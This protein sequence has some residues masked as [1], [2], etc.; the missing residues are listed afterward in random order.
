MVDTGNIRFRLRITVC[1]FLILLLSCTDRKPVPPTENINDKR[2]NNLFE[3]LSPTESGIHF[4]NV[5]KEGPTMNGLVYEYFY[6]G[7]GVAVGDFNGDDL[8]DIYFIS[9]LG[10]N[11]LYLNQGSLKFSDVTE[12]AR[13][14]GTYGFPTGVTTVDINAD[15][16]LD[17]YICKS[18]KFNDPDKRRN[19]LYVNQGNNPQGV[20]IFKEMAGDY[21]LDLPHFSTQ[22]AFFDYDRDG[23]LDMFL[24][25]HGL[26]NYPDKAIGAYK[27]KKSNFRG[28]RLFKNQNGKFIDVT[29]ETGII[30]NMLGFGL[31][32]AVGD[33]NNDGWP[34]IAVGHDYSGKDHIYINQQN[35]TFK[36]VVEQVTGHISNFSMGNDIADYNNDGLLDLITLDMMSEKNYDI[37]TSMSGMNPDRFYRHVDIGLHYQYMYN[38]L[39]LNNGVDPARNL[40]LFSDVAQ[41]AGISSTDWS[42]GPLFLDMDNDGLKDLFVGNGIKRDF[43]NN[44]FV[45]YRQKKQ[46]EAEEAI[47]QGKKIDEQAFV[48]DLLSKMP[49]RK[50]PNYFYANN[51]DLTFTNQS[52]VW[53][54]AVETSSNGAAYADLDNDGDLE[55]I[56]NNSDD[57]S[58]IYKNNT[59]ELGLGNYLRIDFSGPEKNIFGIGARVKIRYGDIQ[60]MQEHYLTRGFQSSVG[61]GLHFGLGKINKVDTVIVTWPD[62]KQQQLTNIAANQTITL[63][64]DKAAIVNPEKKKE[65]KPLFATIT[66][67][68]TGVDWRHEEN[69]FNDFERESLLPHKMSAFGPALATGDFDG[70]GLEDLFLGGAKNQK[71]VLFKQKAN[72]SFEVVVQEGFA[73]SKKYEDVDAMFFDADTDGDLD[74]YLV[75]GGNEEI[76]GSHHYQDRVYENINGKFVYDPDFLPSFKVSG[77]CVR[78]FDFDDDGDLDL[79]VGG[80]QY[81]GRYPTPVSSYLLRNDSEKDKIRFTDITA[82]AFPQLHEIGMVTDAICV[83]L[84]QD[85]KQDLVLV[86]EW[87]QPRIF[88]NTDGTFR[89]MTMEAGFENAS[90]WWNVITAADFD[91][92][93]DLDLVA[94]NLGLNY[95]YKASY[96]KPFKV[97]ATDFDQTGTFDIVLGYYEG[98]DLYPLRGR[99]CSSAQMPF[100]KKKFPTYDAFAKA[101]LKDVYGEDQLGNA[102]QYSAHTFATTYFE[103]QGNGSF[104]PHILPNLAQVSSVNDIV[105]EDFDQDGNL[106]IVLAGNLYGAEVETPRNDAGIGLFLQGDGHGNFHPKPMYETGLQIE[107]E[108]RH[109]AKLELAD[110]R[111]LVIIAVNNRKPIF[112][113]PVKMI[114]DEIN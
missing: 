71:P 46:Y 78:A 42:W 92:D 2:D 6:N 37:K 58:M 50:K 47:K 83:D 56:V 63:S 113:H 45:I 103:N 77:S 18:G 21:N 11:R 40:P 82:Q 91:S 9:N 104:Q 48:L 29:E 39:Q 52:E 28:E 41:L 25:N 62:G 99:Q 16:K 112:V 94:G 22:A 14:Q 33:I 100:I 90:G 95:K 110:K 60:Q 17:I 12:T 13:T 67:T 69:F 68:E 15:G 86:G 96:E 73:D 101:T 61:T 84:N 53:A 35:G 43:R 75:S 20:P 55:I 107:G 34:D 111:T 81:P 97:Y 109:M 36:E 102:I 74:L 31:G 72:S 80:R 87:M 54:D 64:Y 98:S 70:D 24:L 19:E 4:R 105:V 66:A 76:H 8:D 65:R 106:D 23:D 10:S 89:E 44:D 114:R 49:S 32:L 88:Y 5:L 79:F 1:F 26:K 3:I 93:G 85:N 7:A 108:V 59:I 27:G 38:T 51:G 30:N 57:V